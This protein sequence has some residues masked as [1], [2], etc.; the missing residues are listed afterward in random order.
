MA[1]EQ[2]IEA[3]RFKQ[4]REEL[5]LTQSEFAEQLDAGRST[6]DIE[7]GKKKITGRIIA[8]LL[9]QHSINPLWIYGYS[10]NKHIEVMGQTSPK[11]I[12]LNAQER[13][14]MLM[15]P[16]KASAGYADNVQ[17]TDWYESLPTFNIPLPQ[18]NDGSFRAF[19]VEGDSMLPV[20]RNKEW[21]MAKAV[22]S[23][24][25]ANNERIHVVV[26]N[27]MVVV[28]K[29]AKV[30]GESYVKLISLNPEYPTIEQPIDEISELWEVNSH[31]SF[32]LDEPS[33]NDAIT[34]LQQGLESLKIEINKLKQ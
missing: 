25:L 28:K 5:G 15:V 24:R 18:Y 14:N 3:R 23:V 27:S 20:L 12:S 2:N 10:F 4:V 26:T 22:E 17:D 31:L 21:V 6:A 9:R 30:A 29:L 1:P 33:Q 7:R 34:S 11:V 8:Q 13:E 19:Q 16:V 32:D